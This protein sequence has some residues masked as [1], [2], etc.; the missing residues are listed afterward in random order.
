MVLDRDTVPADPIEAAVS[1]FWTRRADQLANLSDGGLAGGVARAVG[2]MTGVRD[3][4][5]SIFVEVGMPEDAIVY[6]PY[7]PGYYRARKRWE[8]VVCY[9]DALVAALE[10]KSQVGSVGKNINNRFEEALGTGTDTWAA[11]RKNSAFGQIP[12]WLGYVFVLRED[13]ETE[14]SNRDTTA[15]F[16]VDSTFIGMSYNE[17]YQEMV[18]RFV[19]DNIYQAGW[20]ITTKIDDDNSVTYA[21]PLFTATARSFRA[22]VKGRVDFVRSIL[23]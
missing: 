18:S 19:G 3:L 12:P 17:R 4:V 22:A 13:D 7:L 21:E 16:N 5:A 23:D 14:A 20:F 6:E 2:H 15:L 9:K 10:F 8:M 11:Q 1:L